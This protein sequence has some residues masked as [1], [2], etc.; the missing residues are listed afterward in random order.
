MAVQSTYGFSDLKITLQHP[1]KGQLQIQGEGVG[2]ITFAMSEDASAHDLAADGSVMTSKIDAPA[3]SVTFSIQQTSSAHIWLTELFNYLNARDN[4]LSEF[5]KI[6]LIAVGTHMRT[7]HICNNMSIKKCPDKP[8]GQ[9]TWE[10]LAG[11]MIEN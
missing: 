9:Q 4:P 2:S 7:E 10:F 1:A 6:T 3:G 11:E 8:Y 5:A